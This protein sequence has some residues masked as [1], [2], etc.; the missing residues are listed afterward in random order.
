[1]T[2][3][4]MALVDGLR[5]GW[6]G[7]AFD[8][9]S[10]PGHAA[11]EAAALCPGCA[12]ICI[13]TN[14]GLLRSG[15]AEASRRTNGS[16]FVF[17]CCDAARIRFAFS[18]G[19]AG[20]VLC[21]PPYGRPGAGRAPADGARR[22]ARIA[23]DSF[24]PAVFV[25]AAGHLLGRGGIVRI[26]ARPSGLVALL[27]AMDSFGLGSPVVH[28]WG[29]P[30]APAVLVRVDGVKGGRRDLVLA[31]QE[32]LPVSAR[33]PASR[34]DSRGHARPSAALPDTEVV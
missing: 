25:A 34:Y 24:G 8:L 32:P 6:E 13:D 22:E 21:N 5:P 16:S 33:P 12:W 15:A 3:D 17:A 2:S 20:L 27:R 10:G 29:A 19:C 11:F 14:P 28:P 31:P 30:G 9:C 26:L 1:M 7:L 18:A 23:P 4:T